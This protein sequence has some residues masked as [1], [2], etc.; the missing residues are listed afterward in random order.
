CERRDGEP[1]A[2]QGKRPTASGC[3]PEEGDRG[4]QT[5]TSPSPGNLAHSLL[6]LSQ[7][8][9][10]HDLAATKRVCHRMFRGR[11]DALGPWCNPAPCSSRNAPARRRT[12]PPLSCSPEKVPGK[13]RYRYSETALA[14]LSRFPDHHPRRR[15]HDQG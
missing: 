3:L 1:F 8:W 6:C 10:T 9:I 12:C 14:L 4:G 13:A 7:G 11:R 15:G 5:A 2:G